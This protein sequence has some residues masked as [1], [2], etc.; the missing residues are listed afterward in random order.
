MRKRGGQDRTDLLID[1]VAARASRL[2]LFIPVRSLRKGMDSDING[3][4]Q[5]AG[6]VIVRG[7]SICLYPPLQRLLMP[8]DA[9]TC[10]EARQRWS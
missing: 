10:R 8:P 1:K 6:A 9:C 7:K 2:G 4:E 3:A 5:G